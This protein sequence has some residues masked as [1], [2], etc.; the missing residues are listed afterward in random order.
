MAIPRIGGTAGGNTPSLGLPTGQGLFN[1]AAVTGSAPFVTGN[2]LGFTNVLTLGAG[3]VY[4]IPPGTWWIKS[5]P[6]TFLQWFDPFGNQW[7]IR[8]CAKEDT[9]FVESDGSNWRL[10]NTTGCPIGAVITTGGA[11]NPYTNGIGTAA[12]GVTVTIS[13]GAS[14]W[15]PVVGGAV[16]LTITSTTAGASP[17]ST[18]GT[19]YNFPPICV[20]DAPPTGGLQATAIVTSL[21]TGTVPAANVQVINQGAGYVSAPKL[22]FIPDPREASATAPGPTTTALQILTLTA[23]GQLTGLYPSAH[24]TAQTS[25]PTLTITTATTTAQATVVMNFTVTG[26]GAYTTGGSSLGSLTLL[27]VSNTIAASTNFLTNPLHNGVGL[28]FPRP[29]RIVATL[30]S[31][32][33]SSTTGTTIEDGGL[34]I[35]QVPSMVPL[36]SIT[37]T[38]AVVP[39]AGTPTVGGITDTSYIQ[40][41]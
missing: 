33:A 9:V 36:Y 30:S 22:T 29:A 23:T 25:V 4:N 15:V 41:A 18:A 37:S 7:K 24:G 13:A 3:E 14:T 12:T 26:Q 5:G 8:P 40:A 31:G 11:T 27:S 38:T 16:S 35:Q 19:G 6:Y 39:Q 2:L 20:I 32:V 34:G 10:A 28:T 21:S 1:N 17:A